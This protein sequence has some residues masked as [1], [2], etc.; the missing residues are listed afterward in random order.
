M[1]CVGLGAAGLNLSPLCSPKLT[2]E[3]LQ[4]HQTVL[5]HKGGAGG[6]RYLLISAKIK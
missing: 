5:A 2:Q 1:G 4:H 3:L 6:M